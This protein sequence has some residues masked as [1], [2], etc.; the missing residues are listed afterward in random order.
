[1]QYWSAKRMERNR[2]DGKKDSLAR[3]K[4]KVLYNLFFDL[5]MN[6]RFVHTQ[7]NQ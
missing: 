7:L 4:S 6:Q 5:K 2:E 1:M 3:K